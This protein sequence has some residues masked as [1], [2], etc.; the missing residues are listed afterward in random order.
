[1]TRPRK[2]GLSIRKCKRVIDIQVELYH[3]VQ[4]GKTSPNPTQISRFMHT[5]II[6]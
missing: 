3:K 4:L 2:H 1:M 5:Y 6:K